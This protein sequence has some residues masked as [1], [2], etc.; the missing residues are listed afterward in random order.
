MNPPGDPTRHF[1]LTQGVARALGLR[2]TEAI[3]SGRITENGF[4]ELVA[5]CCHCPH[6]DACI[7]WLGRNGA[8]SRVAPRFCR[9]GTALE[10]LSR[11]N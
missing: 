8:R 9:N 3:L 2:F 1:W 7:E 6:G 5:A 10:A 11:V 4:A